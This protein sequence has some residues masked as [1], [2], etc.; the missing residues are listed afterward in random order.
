[1][2][3]FKNKIIYLLPL[4]CMLLLGNM[5]II[6]VNA[7]VYGDWEY[8][9]VESEEDEED[10]EDDTLIITNYKG[11]ADTVD[12]PSVIN[13]KT[14]TEIGDFAFFENSFTTITIPDTITTVGG[15]AF[16]ECD[17]LT[18]VT[19]PDSVDKIGKGLFA[20]CTNLKEVKLSANMY[21]ITD[22]M[23]NNCT[24][25]KSINIP[26]SV[27]SIGD[28]AFSGCSSLTEISIPANV[29][30]IGYYPFSKCSNLTSIKV[31]NDNT[32]FN[33]GNGSNV[34]I[35]TAGKVV[36]AGCSK[37]VI[38]DGVEVIG[39]YAFSEVDGLGD[40][41]LPNSLRE[42]E[43]ST[44]ENCS[45]L[46]SVTIPDSVE[47]IG[48]NAFENCKDLV[49]V[50]I[51]K[52]LSKISDGMFKGCES[53]NA[54]TIPDGITEIGHCAFDG[55]TNLKEII[56]PDSVT[57]IRYGAFHYCKSLTEIAIPANVT[58]I[59]ELGDSVSY[60]GSTG[61]GEELN[62]FEDCSSLKSI[63][64]SSDNKVYN[65]GNGSN[66]II[67]TETNNL[68]TGC[69]TTVIPSTVTRIEKSAFYGCSELESITIPDSV[70]VIDSEV[71]RE[72]SNL[73]VVTVPKT[74]K[75]IGISGH[76]TVQKILVAVDDLPL[77]NFEKL[78]LI[79][80]KYFEENDKARVCFFSR[81]ADVGLPKKL[82]SHTRQ[83]LESNG[84][85]SRMAL[86]DDDNN[87]AENTLDDMEEVPIK[88]FVEQ[89]VDE[90]SA[91]KCIRE[92]RL[93]INLSNSA[94]LYLQI[95]GVS[96]GIPQVVSEE[97]QYVRHGLNG[98]IVKHFEDLPKV[99]NYYL[100]SL[101]NWNNAMIQ[102]YEIGEN[103][104]T[105]RLVEKWKEVVKSIG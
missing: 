16:E 56:I 30:G 75:E 8:E 83:V 72:C 55:C 49:T 20:D 68:I 90:L 57:N 42:I 74:V 63:K 35:S 11:Q 18:N 45:G 23:F 88:F 70:T 40:I 48:Y 91:S 14:V 85:D 25:L 36:C 73:R 59:G 104:T 105:R 86:E 98:Q 17:K 3:F 24:S 44:F 79:F 50:N 41:V 54:I 52:N 12:I 32:H 94:N 9:I 80:A 5:I 53:I 10:E 38:P 58:S 2:K 67:I 102:A 76:L 37:S 6:N 13:G 31:S 43:G 1:M 26:E 28:G 103:Y 61:S 47:N 100:S 15:W 69:Q 34:I 96:F 66:A 101:N 77:D 82:L 92:Q 64:V 84:Y 39:E 93:I 27:T 60:W 87:T 21:T 78:V 46:T 33:D 51:P 19:I 71:F 22:L 89:C 62:V 97:S 81:K 29:W 65:D 95:S 99:L 4:I 7:E